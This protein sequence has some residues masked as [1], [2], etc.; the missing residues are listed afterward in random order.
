MRFSLGGL[1]VSLKACSRRGARMFQRCACR[2]AVGLVIGQCIAVVAA[3]D[4]AGS[5]SAMIGSDMVIGR[6][7]DGKP[8]VQRI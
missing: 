5:A 3:A 7:V 8:Q 6:M 1:E 4:C 2:D